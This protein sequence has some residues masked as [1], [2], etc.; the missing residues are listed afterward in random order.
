MA[1]SESPQR[2]EE[3]LFL[4]R[5]EVVFYDALTNPPKVANKVT[6]DRTYIA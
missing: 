2:D 1:F 6:F 4:G 5:S 3:S